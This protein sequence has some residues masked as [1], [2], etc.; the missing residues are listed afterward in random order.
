MDKTNTSYDYTDKIIERNTLHVR[1]TDL[2]LY[3]MM[4]TT[5]KFSG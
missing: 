3:K 1:R 2:M 5:K 4:Q